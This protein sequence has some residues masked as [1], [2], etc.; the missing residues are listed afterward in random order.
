MDT[1][2]VGKRCYTVSDNAPV[3]WSVY[4]SKTSADRRYVFTGTEWLVFETEEEM[5]RQAD[6]IDIDIDID[7]ENY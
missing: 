6:D 3:N 4:L 2:D 1:N 5:E 7:C